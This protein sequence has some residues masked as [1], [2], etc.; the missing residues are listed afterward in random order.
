MRYF[1]IS[2]FLL[3]SIIMSCSSTTIEANEWLESYPIALEQ[4]Q[5]TDKM[6]LLNFTGSDWCG[7]C[8][9]LDEEVFSTP[10]FNE[11]VKE[12]LI[13]LKI[14]F[15]SEIPQSE[16]VKANN[17]ALLEKYGVKG[18]PTIVFID[19]NEEIIAVTGYQAGGA[20]A[21]IEHMREIGIGK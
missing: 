20:L 12:N 21:Y 7:W 13:L 2:L 14:D 16:L 11:F 18:F 4:A 3:L 1:K 17:R 5:K 9:R 19:K 6:I 8:M 10:E 15:P